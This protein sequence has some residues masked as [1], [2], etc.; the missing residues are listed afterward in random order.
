M[1]ETRTVFH[2]ELDGVKRDLVRASARIIEFI[3]RGTEA[4][5]EPNLATA[6]EV[7][8]ADDEIDALT[9]E[10][11]E[12]CCTILALQG[13]VAG[14]LRALISAIRLTAELERSADLMVNVAKATRRIYGMGLPPALRG[15]L[16]SMSQEA[17][18]LFELSMKA[19]A[20][21][22][23]ALAG[24]ID[25]LD[26]RLDQLHHDYIAALL[27]LD[28]EDVELE[29]AVQLGLI[30]RYYE[31]IGDHAVNIAERVQYIV[32]GWLPEHTGAARAAAK[33]GRPWRSAGAPAEAPERT[34]PAEAPPDG[35]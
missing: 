18:R 34:D 13:P 15:L 31:R 14:D 7:I 10:L 25:D 32:H 4:L 21:D 8:E 28:R 30:G 26:D 6:Q 11:E 16:V 17:A 5:L 29:L 19:Y 35:S 24:A 12:R 22:D 3:H 20:D 27:S 23:A 2:Q 9:I 33:A 1:P